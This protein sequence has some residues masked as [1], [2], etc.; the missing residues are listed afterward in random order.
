MLACI[1]NVGERI[2]CTAVVITKSWHLLVVVVIRPPNFDFSSHPTCKRAL[3]EAGGRSR[4]RVSNPCSGAKN[5]WLDSTPFQL[6]IPGR[7]I[8]H[9]ASRAPDSRLR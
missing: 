2:L 5:G 8:S 3:L 7:N 1:G 4:T 6:L 9:S